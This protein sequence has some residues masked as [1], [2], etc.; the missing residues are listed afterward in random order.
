M[1]KILENLTFQTLFPMGPVN[2]IVRP[3]AIFHSLPTHF[4]DSG[5]GDIF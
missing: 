2:G 1:D 5:S 4:V 3:K